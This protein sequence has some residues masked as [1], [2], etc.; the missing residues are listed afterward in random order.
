MKIS[1]YTY[2]RNA[3]ELDYCVGLAIESL[4]RSCD[5][6]VVCDSD[7]TDGTRGLLDMIASRNKKVRVINRKWENPVGDITWFTRWIQDVRKELT[8]EYQLCLDADE[9]LD[10]EQF[11]KY[12]ES[13]N[14]FER[15]LQFERI[16]F[17]RD[18]KTV[19]PHG[20]CCAH[21]V[22]RFGETSYYMPSDEQYGDEPG[23]LKGKEPEIRLN[24]VRSPLRIFHYG[25]LRH[26]EALFKKCEVCLRAFFNT[27]DA[28]LDQA[29][30]HPE[31]HWTTFCQFDRPLLEF[32]GKHPD[33][34]LEWLKERGAI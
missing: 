32:A 30:A 33:I 18:G 21:L 11:N 19:I 25:F 16:N 12:R 20:R 6:V 4:S 1:G 10:S 5:E 13:H 9:V 28:R 2:C 31:V 3:I 14:I 17:W 34:A 15:P 27:W 26:R 8:H 24:S 7:S 23:M 22:T 29:K